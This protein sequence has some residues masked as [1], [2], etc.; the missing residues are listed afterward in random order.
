VTRVEP[1]GGSSESSVDQVVSAF[2]ENTDHVW[3][4]ERHI[5]VRVTSGITYITGPS[6]CGKSAFLRATLAHDPT[7]T[8]LPELA[9]DLA[10]IDHF[11]GSLGERIAF[12][13]RFG[14]G[15]AQVLIRKTPWLSDGQRFRA[16][17][18]AAIHSGADRIMI[19]EFLSTVDRTSAAI[20]AHNVQRI[21]RGRGID[22]VVATAHD[23][24]ANALDPDLLVHVGANSAPRV[25]TRTPG[26]AWELT[27]RI[28]VSQGTLKDYLDLERFHY[29][30]TLDF[31]ADAREI[32]VVTA[33]FDG[34]PVAAHLYCA[35]YPRAWAEDLEQFA[36]MNRRLTLGQRLVVH[37]AFRG[38]G[39]AREVTAAEHAPKGIIYTRSVMSRFTDMHSALGYTRHEPLTNALVGRSPGPVEHD[40]SQLLATEYADYAT[41][42]YGRAAPA[43]VSRVAAWFATRLRDLPEDQ[44]RAAGSITRMGGYVLEK[45]GCDGERRKR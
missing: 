17:V 27:T 6:G 45:D 1:H 44:Q 41:V 34:E 26:E 39:L 12:L 16:R 15:D 42:V 37:P 38:M 43:D 32:S 31:A 36:E 22:L 21:C 19:D 20:V 33:T 13:A 7:W 25:E 9:G 35:P 29:Y 18:A 11:S 24:L 14:L 3:S 30:P 10:L 2:F 5:D 23:D 8:V 40:S 4:N 28:H